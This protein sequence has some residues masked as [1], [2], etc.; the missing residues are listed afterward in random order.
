[1]SKLNKNESG[2][3]RSARIM[4]I[5]LALLTVLGAASAI[6]YSLAF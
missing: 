1:M 5:V 2:Y 4:C 6:I 3:S